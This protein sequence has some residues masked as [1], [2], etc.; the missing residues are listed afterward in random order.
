MKNVFECSINNQTGFQMVDDDTGLSKEI[1][2]TA[3][4]IRYNN[5]LYHILYDS[6]MNPMESPFEFLNFFLS[7]KS[8]NTKRKA[9]QALKLLFSYEVIINKKLAKFKQFDVSNLKKFL[10]GFNTPG[11]SL[12]IVM[13]SSR[14]NSTVNSYLSIYRQYLSFKG[15]INNVLTKRG[16]TH[17]YFDAYKEI[18]YSGTEYIANEKTAN[19]IEVPKYISVDDFKK[20]IE[21]IR[22]DY[23]VREETVVRLMFQCG[24][25]IG[26]VLGLTFE[27]LDVIEE[28]GK[29]ICLAYI[30][31]R[32]SDQ[33]Y[34]L[35]KTCM[36]I[37][38]RKQY[39]QRDYQTRD[40]GYQVAVIPMDLYDL[41][42]D[43]INEFHEK[44][45]TN[46]PNNYFETNVADIATSE[47]NE[48][49]FYIFINSLG[50]PLSQ[51]NWNQ[52]IRKIF[53][54]AGIHID[55]K[56]R[57]HNLNHRLRHGFA[58]FNV[59]HLKL[60]EFELKQRMRHKSLQSVS[61]YF[62]PTIND[63]ITLKNEFVD[64]LYDLYPEL[65]LGGD[66]DE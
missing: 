32:Q 29:Y 19:P 26:E 22:D 15:E 35:A 1:S 14:S 31:N 65:R 52:I 66:Y 4:E 2:Y 60:N 45:R 28:G 38:D 49:N 57:K 7:D 12:N 5:R 16:N 25:R 61:T 37:T 6:R 11:N 55:K 50:R 43:Y 58:M 39:Q 8:E 41:I 44:A 51:A 36:S 13:T 18:S 53:K 62:N 48:D 23:T 30:R 47:D 21:V 42:N 34:Q 9:A 46:H 63:Q 59:Q 33:S 10:H 3:Y 64:S 20:V 54:K 27:D 40:I 56:D 24:L 17:N